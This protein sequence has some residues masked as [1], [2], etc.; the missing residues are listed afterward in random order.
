MAN[1]R[2][3]AALIGAGLTIVGLS[4]IVGVDPKTVER[5]ITKDRVP[6]RV[7]RMAVA[8]AVGK[9]DG[10]LWPTAVSEVQRGETSRD[11]LVGIHP[12]RGAIPMAVWTSLLTQAQRQIDILAFAATFLHDALPEFDASLAERARD[13]VPVRLCLGDP[14]SDAV[15]LRGEEEGIGASLA[16]RCTLTWRYFRPFLD[17][18]NM[19]ARMHGQTL[20]ASMFRFDDDLLVNTHILGAAAGSSPVLQFHHLPGGRIFNHFMDG[21]ERTW[22]SGRPVEG[23]QI[24]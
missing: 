10:F 18:P 9:E 23:V 24:T 1:E 7:H 17:E 12:N 21:F 3:R 22:D 11:E 15:R 2:L 14:A 20:Y 13:G 16:D 5:W 19:A 4:E 8:T 6:H